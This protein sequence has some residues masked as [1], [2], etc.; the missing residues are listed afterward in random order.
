MERLRTVGATQMLQA[1]MDLPNLGNHLVWMQWTI[2]TFKN[3]PFGL[4]T[5]D[6]PVIISNGL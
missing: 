6:R 2:G 1:V 4:L 3:A 5:S